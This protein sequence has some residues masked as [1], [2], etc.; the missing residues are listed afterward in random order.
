MTLKRP[1]AK[2]TDINAQLIPLS[3]EKSGTMLLE[4]RKNG[5]RTK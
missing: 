5:F 2:I 3:D 1:A 4:G